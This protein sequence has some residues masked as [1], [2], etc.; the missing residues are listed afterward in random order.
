MLNTLQLYM[1]MII[2]VLIVATIGIISLFISAGIFA[3]RSIVV[4]ASFAMTVLAAAILA[5]RLW[6]LTR[7][8]LVVRENDTSE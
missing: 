2:A 5:A 3:D 8:P 4:A 7:L 1:E 6:R